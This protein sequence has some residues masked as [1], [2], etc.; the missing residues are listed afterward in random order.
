MRINYLLTSLLLIATAAL[1]QTGD[2]KHLTNVKQ[3]TFGGDNAEAYF[4]FD[5]KYVS[6]QSNN[7][8]WGLQCDQIFYLDVTKG[9]KNPDERPQFISTGKGRTTCSYFMPDGKHILFGSTHLANDSCPPPI[10]PYLNKYLWAVYDTYDIFVSDLKGKVVKQLTTEKGY[11]AEATISPKGDKIV[12]TSTRNGD[13]DLYIMDIDG[14]NVKQITNQLGYDGGAFF[15]PDGKKLVFRSSRPKT[16]EEIAEYKKLLSMGLVAPTDMEIYTCNVDG[17]D[18]RQITKLGKANWA[19]YFTPKGDKIIF[20]SNHHSQRGYDFQLYLIN[21]D[22][23]GLERVTNN[24]IFNAFP[25]FSYD[26]KKLIF[27]SNR[28]NAPGSRD[29]NLYIADWVD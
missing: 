11:D 7:P 17:S 3:L 4:S 18:L 5:S 8:K 16:D 26:G 6:F 14:K 24:S 20:S 12:F 23:T 13:L 21:L 29:T 9:L 27:S 28:N 22:G 19:P 15:S 2:E 10:K 1:A 25:M